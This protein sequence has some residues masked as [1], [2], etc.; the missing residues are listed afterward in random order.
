M[1][2]IMSLCYGYNTN[3]SPCT[4]HTTTSRHENGTVK[5]WD[6][7]A[8]AMRLIYELTTADLFVGQEPEPTLDDFSD[9][10]WPPYKKVSSYDPF[11]DDARLAVKFIE[12]CSFSRTLCVGGSGGQVLT[13]SLNLLTSDIR[14]AVWENAR[15]GECTYGGM[16]VWGNAR[17]GE[18][19]YGRMHVWG[20]ACMG[21]CTYEFASFLHIGM[22]FTKSLQI[23]NLISG[24]LLFV[25]TPGSFRFLSVVTFFSSLYTQSAKAEILLVHQ[26]PQRRAGLRNTSPL[27]SKPD[28]IPLPAGFQATFSLQLMPATTVTAMAFEPN[29]GL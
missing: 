25:C 10:K 4:Q 19:M 22:R 29:W 9:F 27:Q 12:M 1:V 23:Q 8:G 16:H 28:L 2:G 7:T 14:L 6:V 21:E 15:M 26:S 5:F 11:E 18:C 24:F 3:V 20:N 17:M 13:F